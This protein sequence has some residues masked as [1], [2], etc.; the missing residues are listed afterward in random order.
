MLGIGLN[1]SITVRIIYRELVEIPAHSDVRIFELSLSAFSSALKN[2]RNKLTLTSQWKIF[3][4]TDKQKS[5]R[6]I[7]LDGT[8]HT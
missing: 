6:V 3:F 5:S 8:S 7:G 4:R 1:F 2:S